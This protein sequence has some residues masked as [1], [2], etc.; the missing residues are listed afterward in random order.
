MFLYTLIGFVSTYSVLAVAILVAL[1]YTKHVYGVRGLN[2]KVN[3]KFAG[4]KFV[5]VFEIY[6]YVVL[7]AWV[8]IALPWL[9]LFTFGY[10]TKFSEHGIITYFGQFEGRQ[11][12]IAAKAAL[13]LVDLAHILKQGRV[14]ILQPTKMFMI[15]KPE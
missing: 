6:S 4:K 7:V 2:N 10:S 14:V 15:W 9:D 13:N 11:A 12:D 5:A 3:Q 8:A 1:L